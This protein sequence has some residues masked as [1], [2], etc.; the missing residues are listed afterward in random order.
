[1]VYKTFRV[2]C[3]GR[4]LMLSLSLL[5]FFYLLF[6]TDLY[7]PLFIT[8][9]LIVYQVY[10]LIHYVDK[11]NRDLARFFNSIRYSD[12][13]QSFKEKNVSRSFK[14]LQDAFT[15]VTEAFR[16]A[17]AE[18]EE[19]Y[20]YLQ[21]IVQHVAIGLI[22]FTP[23]GNVELINNAAKRLL[24]LPRLKNIQLL[25]S[26]SDDLVDALQRLRPR[27][28][29][30]VKVEDDDELLQLSL[31]AT[32]F[33]L[34]GRQFSLVSLQNIQSELEEKEIEAWQKLIRVLT[35]EIMNSITP[36][37]S[38]AS[39]INDLL[40]DLPC[41]D[42]SGS[43]EERENLIDIKQAVGTIQNRSRGLL[44]F[45]DAYR[46]LTLIPI[47]ELQM[48]SVRELFSRI[49][50]LMDSNIKEKAIAFTSVIEP[51]DLE[52]T[53]DTELIEQVLIN[54][55]LNALQAVESIP[56]PVI[57]LRS[58]HDSRGRI[59][60]QIID[61]GPGISK[62]NLEKIFI[63]FFSTKEGGSG[64]GLSLSRQIMRQHGGAISVHSIPGKST[65][66]TLRF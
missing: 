24:N 42:H 13:S 29:A 48:I 38:L 65:V 62:E 31:Y 5:F 18:K 27:E 23:D 8:A 19:H 50:R 57:E 40:G 25:R 4:V 64:I 16:K 10:G 51:A 47:P 39:T 60:I 43:D 36:I 20:R 14:L 34:R 30:L 53:A 12:F 46:N 58:Q 35:H 2:L 7:A 15:D 54:L 45:V 61:N 33:K 37:S 26:K 22:A 1:M 63:P 21:T 55:L 41:S 11:T 56:C 52:L 3:V 9:L 32:G 17:R 66:F 44:H 28:S 49:E 59:Q 6:R